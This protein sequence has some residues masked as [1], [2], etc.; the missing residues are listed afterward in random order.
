[1]TMQEATGKGAPSLNTKVYEDETKLE[2]ASSSRASH[3]RIA[4]TVSSC[5]LGRELEG[6]RHR[7]EYNGLELYLK[8]GALRILNPEMGLVNRQPHRGRQSW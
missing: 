8:F 7:D 3:L 6:L 2:G 4:I 1:L 5:V